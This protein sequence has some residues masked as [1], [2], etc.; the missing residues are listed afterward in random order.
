MNKKG[1]VFVETI[2]TIVFLAAALLIL[3]TSYRSAITEEREKVYYDDIGY[4]YR[5]YYIADYLINKSDIYQKKNSQ[6][7][8][9]YIMEVTEENVNN[10][11]TPEQIE[12]KN[13]EE[14]MKIKERFNVNRMLLVSDDVIVECGQANEKC[15][16]SYEGLNDGLTEYIKTMEI[17]VPED[18]E[19]RTNYYLVTEYRE[20][21][22]NE[23]IKK[24]SNDEE[25]CGTFYVK[26]KLD[27][28]KKIENE[29]LGIG[30]VCKGQNLGRCI[31]ENYKIEN[32]EDE[33]GNR[34][35]IFYHDG[36]SE[37]SGNGEKEAKDNSYRYGG[38]LVNNWVCF[39]SDAEVCPSENLY[40]IIGVFG[41]NLKIIRNESDNK[42]WNST[43]TI[44]KRTEKK[45]VIAV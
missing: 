35:G 16:T 38:N 23:G 45:A 36:D 17:E 27:I 3:Y 41:N 42:T 20:K 30:K 25:G 40:R 19:R 4:L 26:L 43:E 21:S 14:L 9:K 39:G 37:D 31:K 6:F 7:N 11:F 44:T 15:E 12:A 8:E 34:S 18:G 10:L 24:C 32:V 22:T 28:N 29:D 2:I 1:F 13:P 33:N 5:N